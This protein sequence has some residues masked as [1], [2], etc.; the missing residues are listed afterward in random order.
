MQEDSINVMQREE[1]SNEEA[2]KLTAS[3]ISEFIPLKKENLSKFVPGMYVYRAGVSKVLIPNEP[4]LTVI[5][6]VQDGLLYCDSFEQRYCIGG[7]TKECLNLISTRGDNHFKRV[8]A[9]ALKQIFSSKAAVNTALQRIK[10]NVWSDE[11]YW[12]ENLSST[13]AKIV[14]FYEGSE[15]TVSDSYGAYLRPLL[16]MSPE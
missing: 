8:N 7:K 16:V 15:R 3:E 10:K 14:E 11:C 1:I 2:V 5:L 13:R 9:K 4:V 6:F 12:G